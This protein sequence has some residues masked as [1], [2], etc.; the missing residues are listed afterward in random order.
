MLEHTSLV[1]APLNVGTHYTLAGILDSEPCVL[2]Q[3]QNVL[4]TSLALGTV[5][6]P[7]SVSIDANICSLCESTMHLHRSLSSCYA[8]AF[9]V[10]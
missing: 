9:G 2:L 4:L 1:C 10:V 7:T 8:Q 6:S 5:P 3:R